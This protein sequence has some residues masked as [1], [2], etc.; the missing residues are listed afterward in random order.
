LPGRSQVGRGD[1]AVKEG[2]RGGTTGSPTRITLPRNA[3]VAEQFDLLAD[4]LELAGEQQFRVL[5][6]RRAADQIRSAGSPIAQLAL[7]G[8][9]KDLPG[10]GKTIESK[11]VQIVNTGEIE[12]L[13]KRK[14]EI[15]EGVAEFLRLPALGPKT[16]RRIW[17]EL[18]I[19][20]VEELR[21]AAEAERLRTLPGLGAK[22]EERILKALGE[23]PQE[24][25]TL[26]AVALPAVR[27]VVEVLREHPASNEV[28]EAGSVRRRAETVK[29]LD[30]IATASD[31]AA[32]TDYLTKLTWVAEIEA[33]GKTKATVVSHD[34]LRFDLRVVPP[35]AYGNLLQHFTG[36]KRHNVALRE[37]AVRRGLSV[38]EYGV[39]D[40]ETGEVFTARTEEE[41]YERLGYEWIPPEL[42]EGR[43]E[44]EPARKR[45]LP[46]LVELSDLRGDLHMHSTWSNDGKNTLEEMATAAKA[47]GYDY[48]AI[49]D[50]AHYLRDGR[51][52][53]Q[54]KEIAKL[55]KKLAPFR[56]LRG[57]E[58]SIR[59]DGTLDFSDEQLAECDWVMA[60]L[61]SAFEKSPTER[62]LS[63]MENPHVDCI[64]HPTTRKLNRRSGIDIDLERVVAK[65]LETGTYL[66]INSQ[67]DRLD[68]RDSDARV[69]GEAGL[70]LAISTDSHELGALDFAELG[71]AQA[72]R[73]WLTKDQ[74]VNTRPW[75][76]IK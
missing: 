49:T 22:T 42:R 31:P 66:E 65:G 21:K 8:R 23:K 27:A 64:G 62:I 40:V 61:H 7:D 70:P 5:A 46:A 58:V 17:Q 57:I 3:H 47:R 44:L 43:G 15:P 1:A 50:H 68:L 33:K 59:V 16:A 14:A 69:V 10:I 41:L 24:K 26:L 25:G 32:L 2:V 29:D 20:T 76:D 6:Y 45:E 28:S 56:L 30:I 48:V 13:T 63:A 73:A 4:L 51:F 67:P 18:G 35:E 72:R 74:I 60:S 54:A 12:V 34:G 75:E 52:E 11:I 38:S 39:K 55:Q 19:T 9:A 37:D 71:V 53:G 36:S